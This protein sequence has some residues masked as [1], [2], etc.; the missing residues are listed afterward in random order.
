MTK[1]KHPETYDSLM[2]ICDETARRIESQVEHLRGRLSHGKLTSEQYYFLDGL[3]EF[4]K[5]REHFRGEN[6]K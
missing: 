6:E 2:K 5:K 1:K 3:L 4:L